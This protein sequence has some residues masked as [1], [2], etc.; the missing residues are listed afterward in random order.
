MRAQYKK[1][2]RI[3]SYARSNGRLT[4][5]LSTLKSMTIKRVTDDAMPRP[6]PLY[7]AF[8][9]RNGAAQD[10]CLPLER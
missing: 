5:T 6:R 2:N 10:G 3:T 1:K 9:L 4:L 7:P 8:V